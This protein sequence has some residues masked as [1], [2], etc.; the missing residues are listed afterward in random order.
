MCGLRSLRN[1]EVMWKMAPSLGI[2]KNKK[3]FRLQR[4]RGL[5]PGPHWGLRPQTPE[6]SP[7]S[8][9]ATTPLVFRLCRQLCTSPRCPSNPLNYIDDREWLFI[10]SL[11]PIPIHS[12]PIPN[13][14]TYP[15]SHTVPMGPWLRLRFDYDTT[16]GRLRCD[17]DVFPF[18]PIPIPFQNVYYDC[19]Q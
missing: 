18:P 8:K 4:V 13:F 19:K 6:R 17:Y 15:H 2:S 9:F 14:V 10:F 5:C 16:T 11:P 12:I 3:S 1:F 7:S